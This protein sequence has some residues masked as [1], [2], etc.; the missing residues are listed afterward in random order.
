MCQMSHVMCNMSCV[1]NNN[2]KKSDKVVKLLGG[3]SVNG[4]ARP[5]FFGALMVLTHFFLYHRVP[6]SIG[7]VNVAL[8]GFLLF[9]SNK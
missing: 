7:N 8:V 6:S 4:A 2:D 3:G 5:V 9:I 1:N